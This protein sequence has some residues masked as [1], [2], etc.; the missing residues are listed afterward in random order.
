VDFAIPN[1]GESLLTAFDRWRGW[2][3]PKVNCDYS[4][5]VA[6]VDW[7]DRVSHEMEVLCKERGVNSYKVFMAYKVRGNTNNAYYNII[8]KHGRTYI[9]SS[10]HRSDQI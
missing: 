1:K 3:D 4:L 2:A 5:H 9:C 10:L 7:N 8:F 6:I